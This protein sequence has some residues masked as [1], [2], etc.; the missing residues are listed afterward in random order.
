MS[1]GRTTVTCLYMVDFIYDQL[2]DAQEDIGNGAA[3]LVRAARSAVCNIYA[4]YPGVL[5]Y[6]GIGQPPS[7]IARA[8][9]DNICRPDFP[10]P[11]LPS[12]GYSG[13]QCPVQY[14][15]GYS[16]V[17]EFPPNPPGR[18]TTAGSVTIWGTFKG[19]RV[20]PSANQWNVSLVG[21][22]NGAPNAT[23]L[24]PLLAIANSYSAPVVTI[25]SV[26]RVDGQP[27]N[28]GNP[29]TP[30]P[31]ESPPQNIFEYDVDI[32]IGGTTITSPLVVIQTE[33][34]NSFEYRPEINV[35][36]GGILINFQFDGV[37]I[38]LDGDE[39]TPLPPPITPDPRPNAPTLPPKDGTKNGGECPDVDLEPVL[40]AIAN[41]Q[42]V[43]EVIEGNVEELLNC[44]RCNRLPVTSTEYSRQSFGAAQSGEY[45]IGQRAVWVTLRLNDVPANAKMQNGGN[46]RDVLY[47][48]WYTFGTDDVMLPRRP[49]QYADNL[50][51]V[52]EGVTKFSY[53][54]YTGFT[55]STTVHSK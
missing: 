29:E 34:N 18:F 52:P 24:T 5:T 19:T 7:V 22:A 21:G 32:D 36:I 53:T 25:T 33:N 51:E 20:T 41:V 17:A 31:I 47:A 49:I 30:D 4:N 1:Y 9:Y 27:D 40:V 10:P 46:T 3:N 26:T 6:N 38:N 11:A 16:I 50:L 43:V 14:T 23:V 28:C 13:G 44:D 54:V 37:R 48:G 2:R 45:E 12:P 15:I 8:F 35:D 42:G 39:N 55:A